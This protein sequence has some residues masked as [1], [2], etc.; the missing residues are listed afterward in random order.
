MRNTG[1]GQKIN[2][3]KEMEPIEEKIT[4]EVNQSISRW[5]HK[6]GNLIMVLHA[7][8]GHYGY[9]PWNISKHL[10]VELSVPLA[11]IYEVITF[12]NYFNLEP[13]AD[14]TFSVCTG[15]ACH[16]KGAPSIISELRKV[17]KIQPKS[18]YSVDRTYKLEEVRCIGCCGLAPAIT[19][20]GEVQGRIKPENLSA[21]VDD[22]AQNKNS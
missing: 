14:Y 16:L 20:N 10:A 21:K 11:R 18:V 5:K 2:C 13:P 6:E 15:T 3:V 9:I 22:I 19:V 12:Y 7:V 1:K 17:L 4:E 8:Q